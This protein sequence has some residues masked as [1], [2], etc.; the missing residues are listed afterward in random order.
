MSWIKIVGKGLEYTGKLAQ[1]KGFEEW[2]ENQGRAVI[3]KLALDRGFKIFRGR[4]AESEIFDDLRR[5]ATSE[6]LKKAIQAQV[7]NFQLLLGTLAQKNQELPQTSGYP[8]VIAV[9]RGFHSAAAIGILRNE[10]GGSDELTRL[11]GGEALKEFFFAELTQQMADALLKTEP[12]IKKPVTSAGEWLVIGADPN[13]KW[14]IDGPG[15][16]YYLFKP[17]YSSKYDKDAQKLA[18]DE[19]DTL[20]VY[21]AKLSRDQKRAMMEKANAAW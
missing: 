6:A 10:L 12:S 16:H 11:K 1:A 7:A 8:P 3:E 14:D 9:P 18:A 2:A 17:K 21:L 19:L 4:R 15:G 20:A 13:F 5:A